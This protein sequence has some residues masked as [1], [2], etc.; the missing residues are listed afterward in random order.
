MDH[1][2]QEMHQGL[3]SRGVDQVDQIQGVR[4]QGF[5]AALSG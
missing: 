5:D 3:H 1:Y 4:S 2:L